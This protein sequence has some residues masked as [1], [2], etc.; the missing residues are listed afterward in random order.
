MEMPRA[1]RSHDLPGLPPGAGLDYGY[2]MRLFLALILVLCG[3]G[4][5]A[6][7]QTAWTELMPGVGMRLVSADMV[8]ADGIAWLGLE[9]DMPPDVKTYW[10]VPGESGIPLMIDASES[11]GIDG[12][13]IAWPYPRRE[14]SRGYLDHA[15]YGHVLIPLAATVS[16]PE[17]RMVAEISLGVC[18]EVCVPVAV[19][20]DLALDLGRPDATNGLR[21]R[22]ALAHVPLPHDGEGLLGAARFDASARRLE[23]AVRDPRLDPAAMIA[24]IEGT[25]VLFDAP[26][27]RDDGKTLAFDLLGRWPETIGPAL[28]ARFTFDTEDGPYEITRPLSGQ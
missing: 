13:E 19:R 18:A 27:L 9:L 15:Y 12:I 2:G 17:P 21:I 8:G 22:Q 11:D 28:T 14:T 7:A 20:F 25:M 26:V 3:P 24:E 5:L 16:G 4:P 10:R 6:A 23:V 1:S